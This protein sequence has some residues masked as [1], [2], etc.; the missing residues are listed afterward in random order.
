MRRRSWLAGL[1]VAASLAAVRS[2]RA[3]RCDRRAGKAL[4][5]PL[6]RR[7]DGVIG[8]GTDLGSV[9]AVIGATSVLAATGRRRAARRVAGAG[10][11]AWVAAQA[12]KP[13]V[14]RPRPY[15]ADGATR[16]VTRP[17]GASWPSGHVAVATGMASA[18]VDELPRGGRLSALLGALFVAHSR[19]YVGVHYL[20]D[21]VAGLG[22]GVL[23]ERAW[24]A[25]QRLMDRRLMDG[26][27]GDG[28]EPD[29][30]GA[31]AG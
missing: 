4:S 11:L 22:I 3:Q 16:L 18:V 17:A 9:Y 10:A 5:R 14:D 8:V 1:L 12:A 28:P 26:P 24:H 27:G 7:A 31:A 19:V 25:V 30:A 20:S 23:A 13:L 2:R 15:E 6:G 29:G 21:V